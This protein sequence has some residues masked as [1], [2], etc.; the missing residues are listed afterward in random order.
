MKGIHTIAAAVVLLGFFPGV[1]VGFAQEKSLVVAGVRLHIGMPFEEVLERFK[2]TRYAVRP[3]EGARDAYTIAAQGGPP[4]ES[5]GNLTFRQGKLWWIGK[6]WGNYFGP[7]AAAMFNALFGM[8]AARQQ[9]KYEAQLRI[10]ET[11]EPGVIRHEVKINLSDGRKISLSLTEMQRVTE[12][13]SVMEMV[14]GFR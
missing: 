9:E 10:V 4:F 1:E 11:R 6:S 14:G 13:V 8:M 7:D 12:S 2:G 5:P 3:L